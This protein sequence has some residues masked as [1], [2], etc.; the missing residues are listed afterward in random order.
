VGSDSTQPPQD[1]QKSTGWRG[2][3]GRGENLD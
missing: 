2:E 3:V 1:N